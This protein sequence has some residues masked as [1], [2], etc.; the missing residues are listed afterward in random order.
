MKT[1]NEFTL[2]IFISLLL[3]GGIVHAQDDDNQYSDIERKTY[4]YKDFQEM[5]SDLG[6]YVGLVTS[7]IWNRFA[8]PIL[9]TRVNEKRYKNNVTKYWGFKIGNNVYRIKPDPMGN[10]PVEILGKKDKYFYVNGRFTIE[11]KC[12]NSSHKTFSTRNIYYSE[13]LES[14][15]KYINSLKKT[16]NSGPEFSKL[17]DCIKENKKSGS[18][19]DK[20]DNKLN[21][22]I[23]FI[24]KD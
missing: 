8:K 13:T 7:L 9:V 2:L 10:F 11:K 12:G 23:N 14:K 16:E 4:L 20:F 22:V 19:Q 17:C 3:F 24:S 1:I 21:C 15:L 6:E 18:E 5:E